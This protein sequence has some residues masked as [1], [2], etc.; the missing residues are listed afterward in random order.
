MANKKRIQ[1]EFK[2]K[3]GIRVDMI[4]QGA[5]TSNTG[6]TLRQFFQNPELVAEITGVKEELIQRFAII[7]EVIT[8]GEAIKTE[9]FG[10]YAFET[11][12]YFVDNYN[13]YYMPVTVHKVL[14][15]AEKIIH[16]AILQSDVYRKK[17]KKPVIKIINGIAFHIPE[18]IIV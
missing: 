4:E 9:K 15:H 8:S 2:N 16:A 1:K 13:G 11:A 6:N 5:G 7:L 12:K 18:N 17:L 14:L 3:M 10:S